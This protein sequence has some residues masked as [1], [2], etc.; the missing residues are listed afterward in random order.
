[1]VRQRELGGRAAVPSP[2]R[3]DEERV[4]AELKPGDHPG[5][6]ARRVV[7]LKRR[8]DV[9]AVQQHRRLLHRHRAGHA[10]L[11]ERVAAGDHARGAR[12]NANR[13]V[14]CRLRSRDGGAAERTNAGER[15]PDQSPHYPSPFTRGSRATMAGLRP[16]GKP[17]G[18]AEWW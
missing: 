1:M 6:R 7:P 15:G 3:V 2:V 18:C 16:S 10:D 13:E 8:R 12:Q 4:R 11:D 9:G 14:L 5:V 17:D